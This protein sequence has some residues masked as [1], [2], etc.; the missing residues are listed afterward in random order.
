MTLA[1]AAVRGRRVFMSRS[2]GGGSGGVRVVQERGGPSSDSAVAIELHDA[3]SVTSVSALVA[4]HPHADESMILTSVRVNAALLAGARLAANPQTRALV[5]SL[6]PPACSTGKSIAA[7]LSSSPAIALALVDSGVDVLIQGSMY[8]ASRAARRGA[9]SA[10][11]PVGRG[12]LEPVAV[13]V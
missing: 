3:S 6:L 10:M 8:W 9:T 1:A 7:F 4:P 5:Q 2:V 13:V 11:Y 12:Q